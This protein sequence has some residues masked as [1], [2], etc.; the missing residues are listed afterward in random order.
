[1]WILFFFVGERI[2]GPMSTCDDRLELRFDREDVN[3][4]RPFRYVDEF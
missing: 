2:G 4:V 1:M 3:S